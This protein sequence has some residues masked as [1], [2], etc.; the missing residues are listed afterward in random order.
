[1]PHGVKA[2]VGDIF[3]IPVDESRVGYGQIVADIRPNPLLLAVYEPL[4]P[5][6]QAAPLQEIVRAPI[7]FLANS[8]DSKIW[9][10]QWPVVGRI[11]P[12]LDRIPFP[13]FKTTMEKAE[14]YYVVSY[15][16]SRR[17]RA[18]PEEI[19]RL[20]F[21]TTVAPQ[22]LENAL[23]AQYGLIPWEAGFERLRYDY[24]RSRSDSTVN[25]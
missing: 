4:F 13:A 7:L 1:M 22:R 11:P 16:G 6:R 5:R 18:T 12:S 2:K 3:Q 21:R 20:D 23:K 14:D 25:W 15:D 24:V 19:D 10:E 8:L 9:H 17:R